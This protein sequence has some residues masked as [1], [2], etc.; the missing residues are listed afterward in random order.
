MTAMTVA[1]TR[2]A[3]ILMFLEDAHWIDPTTLDLTNRIVERVRHLPILLVITF[4]P[5]FSPPWAGRGHVTSLSLT[6]L[7]RPQAI[8]MIGGVA[9]GKKLPA[10][11]F[12][13]IVAK[14][15][16]VP[17]FMEELT[18]SVLESGLLREESDSYVLASVLTPLAIPSTLHDSLTA[19]LDRLSPI[20]ETAQ[21]AAAIGR[22]FS[23]TL[24]EAVSPIKGDALEAILQQ[25]MEAELIHRR[26]TPPKAH[27][28]FKHALVQDAAY[29]SMLRG[30]RQAIHAQIARALQEHDRRGASAS[31][32]R[33]S[34]HRGRTSGTCGHRLARRGRARIVTIGTGRGRTAFERRTVA[35]FQ[36]VRGARA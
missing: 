6:R 35:D 20:K 31:H 25:L 14:T 3:P 2:R 34:P 1:L 7:A 26:G 19:R 17:L 30:R 22:E 9:S 28:T 5:E 27:Y 24:I 13:Q 12:D 4:R 33:P 15:D 23:H 10:E 8:R 21:I 11:V 29:G 36:C 18:K 16:G 32:H